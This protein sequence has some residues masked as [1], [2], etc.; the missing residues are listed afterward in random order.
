M[1]PAL[2]VGFDDLHKRVDAQSKQ[3][4]LHQEKLKVS[5][6]PSSSVNLCSYLNCPKELQ[7]R[8]STL[9]QTHLLS[10]TLRTTRALQTHTLITHRLLRLIEHIHLLIPS[11]RSAA[12]GSEEEALRAKLERLKDEVQRG[13]GGGGGR[14]RVN[15]L[16]ALLGAV[17]AAKE[18]D[19]GGRDGVEW[20]VVD[21]EG[22]ERLAMVCWIVRVLAFISDPMPFPGSPRFWPSNNRA[23]HI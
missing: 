23:L 19:A 5:L 15:E 8:L 22:L 18:R 20:K 10:N 14:G 1:V 6:L 13:L 21:Q 2:A 4:A 9:S 16:W 11:L 7:T 3:A 12:I 17:K